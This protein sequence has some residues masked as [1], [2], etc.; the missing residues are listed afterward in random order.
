MLA[1]KPGLAAADLCLQPHEQ[2]GG[3]AQG[4]LPQHLHILD[5]FFSEGFDFLS[6]GL[7]PT[8]LQLSLL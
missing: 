7:E 8:G 5:A 4:D 3:H 2:L 6:L 1:H